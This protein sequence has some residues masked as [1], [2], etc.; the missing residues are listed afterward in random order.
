MDSKSRFSVKGSNPVRDY[1]GLKERQG[2]YAPN[3]KEDVR[4]K[5]DEGGKYDDILIT[6]DYLKL[7]DFAL[8]KGFITRGEAQSIAKHKAEFLFSMHSLYWKVYQCLQQGFRI[9]WRALIVH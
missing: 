5:L 7:K 9:F 2:R 4:A 6:N 1:Q 3:S 8:E